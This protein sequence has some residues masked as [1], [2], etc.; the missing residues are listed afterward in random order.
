[1]SKVTLSVSIDTSGIV[2]WLLALWTR[3]FVLV[4]VRTNLAKMLKTSI[5]VIQLE[6]MHTC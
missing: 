5:R 1:M 6:N 4:I 3:Q 2:N